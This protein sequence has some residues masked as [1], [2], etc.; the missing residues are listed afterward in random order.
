MTNS[1]L[2]RRTFLGGL[3]TAAIAAMLR[4]MLAHAETGVAPQRLLFIH[5]PC[6]SSS[7]SNGRWWPS[8]G[9]TGWQASPLLSSFTDGKIASLQ[10]RMVVLRG[11]TC[12][13]N[14]NWL[15]DAHGSGY[16]GMMTPPPKDVGYNTRPQSA[17]ATP[18]SKADGHSK[19]LTAVDQSIDQLF[20]SQIPGLQGAAFPSIQL[21]ASTESS[22]Q[23]NDL[24][25]LR[26][27][28]YAKGPNGALPRALWPEVSPAAAFKN[29][30]G[31]GAMG[32]TPSD[33]LRAAAQNKSV[34][35]FAL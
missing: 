17:S 2:L 28:S 29:Y 24:H 10:D 14:M 31:S 22:D 30:F 13:R 25:C 16:L 1:K 5:R 9:A 6:G 3:G 8:G 23:N 7:L 19:T 26:V 33:A 27:T 21:S 32:M 18:S 4:P 11:L 34:L 35:D 20:L 15:G 12:P